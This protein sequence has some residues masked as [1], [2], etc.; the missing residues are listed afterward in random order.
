MAEAGYPPSASIGVWERMAGEGGTAVPVFLSTHP[1]HEKRIANQREWL[2]EAKKKY[3]RNKRSG[4]AGL[5][6]PIW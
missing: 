4:G 1:S 3:Q 6:E 5:S 2:P